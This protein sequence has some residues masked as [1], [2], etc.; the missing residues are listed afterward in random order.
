MRKHGLP[1]NL[2]QRDETPPGKGEGIL[3]DLLRERYVGIRKQD[4]VLCIEM[5]IRILPPDK[6]QHR[7]TLLAGTEPEP[8]SELLQKDGHAFGGTQ[9][10]DRVHFGDI[11][12]FV[13]QVNNENK[14][15]LFRS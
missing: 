8:P 1:G 14:T 4:T 11:H 12:P 7:E 6:V 15:D 10:Q 3:P 2:L 5:I 9:E 13:V